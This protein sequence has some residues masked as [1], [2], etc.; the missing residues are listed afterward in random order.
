MIASR[1]LSRFSSHLRRSIPIRASSS[2]SYP[3]D[4]DALVTKELKG[5]RGPDSLEWHTPEGI[6]L[7]PVYTKQD[8]ENLDTM[9]SAE[10]GDLPG[11]R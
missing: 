8:V 1:S 11:T 6:V 7:K 9:S 5:K 4:W 3:A 2:S 10:S